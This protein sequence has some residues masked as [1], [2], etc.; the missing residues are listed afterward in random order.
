MISANFLLGRQQASQSPIVAAAL[1]VR[2]FAQRP[3]KESRTNFRSALSMGSRCVARY[4][5]PAQRTHSAKGGKACG[6]LLDA[7]A[8]TIAERATETAGGHRRAAPES[9]EVLEW[10]VMAIDQQPIALAAYMHV[11]AEPVPTRDTPTTDPLRS[12]VA[13]RPKR[14][15]GKTRPLKVLHRPLDRTSSPPRDV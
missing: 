13:S 7:P 9:R 1:L 11:P 3:S 10:D 6:T 2:L 5:N 4:F 12:P 15:R 14:R 8:A